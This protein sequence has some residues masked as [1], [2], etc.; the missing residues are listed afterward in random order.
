M[1]RG[2][3]LFRPIEKWNIMK[4][5]SVVKP[6]AL[7]AAL[8]CMCIVGCAG[9]VDA[10]VAPETPIGVEDPAM[11]AAPA[12]DFSAEPAADAS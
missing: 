10:P 9:E 11:E 6:I 8:A 4:I 12:E 2:S 7:L 5:E 3:G 1:V